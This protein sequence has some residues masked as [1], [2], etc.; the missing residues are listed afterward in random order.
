MSGK[1]RILAAGLLVLLVSGCMT[2]GPDYEQPE[3]AVPDDWSQEAAEGISR[4][5]NE[6]VEWWR[7]FNDPVLDQLVETC[8]L[9]TS[10]AADEV[11]PV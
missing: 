6:L 1:L 5:P 7:V 8:L 2:V 4:A 3:V 9:Y 10:D 11:V